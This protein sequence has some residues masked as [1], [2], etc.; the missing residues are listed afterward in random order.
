ML[1]RERQDVAL[2]RNFFSIEKVAALS[3]AAGMLQFSSDIGLGEMEILPLSEEFRPTEG[4]GD[5]VMMTSG[6]SGEPKGVLLDVEKVVLNN[7]AT[8]CIVQPDRCDI[9][10]IDLDMALMSATSHMIMAWQYKIPCII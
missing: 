1:S 2:A 9:W 8:G 10:A 4:A 5:L 3:N 6:S 7:T